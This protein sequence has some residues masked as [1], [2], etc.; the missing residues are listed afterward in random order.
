MLPEYYQ[1]K[2]RSLNVDRSSGHPKPHKVC[3]LLA[4]IDLIQRGVLAENRITITDSLKAAFAAHFEKF[5][6]GNDANNIMLPFYHLRGDGIWHF[7][8]TSG[9][10]DSFEALKE[11]NSSPSEKA[12]FDVIDYAYLDEPLF[13]SLQEESARSAA[14][15]LLLEKLEDLSVQ[16]QRWL[17]GMG[18]SERTAD[19]YVGAIRGTISKWAADADVTGQNLI[20]IQ[21]YTTI[22]KVAE[23]LA[24]YAVFNEKNTKGKQM[25]SAALNAYRDFLAD[26][27]QVKLTEDIEEIVRNKKI[28]DTQKARLVNTRIG[29]GQFREDLIRYWRGCAVTGYSAK[30]FLVA[31]HIKPWRDSSNEERLNKYNGILLL[32][33]L[34]KAFDLGYISFEHKGLI[35]ISEFIESPQM[36]GIRPELHIAL[37]TEHEDFMAYHREHVFERKTS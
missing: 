32:P 7:N 20:S 14:R 10:E 6:K 3:L 24:Q 37:A 26:T 4:V 2:L 12:L 17:L 27:C 13:Q 9:K 16:F 23:Q 8:I 18:K 36:L 28:D 15:Q 21:S 30:Q 11:K 25:Y 33:N 22:N 29:Q 1:N 5:K 34:D 35:K 31:S 19:S